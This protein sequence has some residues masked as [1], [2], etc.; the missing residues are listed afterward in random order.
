MMRAII[1]RAYGRVVFLGDRVYSMPLDR[2]IMHPE[3]MQVPAISENVS[4]TLYEV[5]SGASRPPLSPSSVPAV[6]ATPVAKDYLVLARDG[7]LIVSKLTPEL[8]F[9]GRHDGKSIANIKST[10]GEVPPQ[11]QSLIAS[12]KILQVSLAELRSIGEEHTK[13]I[14][15]KKDMA[16]ARR[17]SGRSVRRRDDSS[18]DTDE[19]NSSPIKNAISIRI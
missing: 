12:G 3:L 11:V 13:A 10:Y 6:T 16:E 19:D 14:Q 18:D 2:V 15:S 5:M 7:C 1:D 17:K 4:G 9:N 8:R